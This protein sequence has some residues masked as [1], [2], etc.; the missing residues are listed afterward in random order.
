MN[1][2]LIIPILG[3][4][5]G[6]H[7]NA[8][9]ILYVPM[10]LGSGGLVQETVSGRK[11]AVNGSHSPENV[12]GASGK[13][14]RLDGYSS[15]V[16]GAIDKAE[17]LNEASFSLW[18]APE[19][20]PVI[21]HD[22][23]T[24]DRILMGG[25]LSNSN[26]NGWGFT[27]GYTG[28]YAF[29]A[30]S[31]GWKV[32][33][34]A[35][36]LLPTYEWSHLVAVCDSK[37]GTV[38]LYRNG[39]LVGEGRTMAITDPGDTL[40]IGKGEEEIKSGPFY[41]NTFNGLVDELEVF[42]TLMTEEEIRSS[43]PENIADLTIPE[44]RFE[45]EKLRPVF[46]GMPGA[47]WT[48]ESHGML[49]ADGRYHVFFQKN[50]NG[51]YMSRL[52]WGH[53]SSENLYDWREEKIAIAPGENYDIKGCWSG[54][55]FVD[56]VIG[57]GKPSIVYTAVDY[58]R[59]VI[60]QAT[61]A[62]EHL[63]EWDKKSDNPIIN[64]RPSGLSDDFRDPYFFRNGDKA[65]II[66]GSSKDGV[67]TTTLHEYN[68][69]SGS[70]SN[71]GRLFF[72]GSS[73]AVAGEFWEMPNVTKM[74]D[75]KW[76]FTCTPLNTA[77]GVKTL[78]WTGTIGSDGKFIPD[79]YSSMPRNFELISKQGYGLLSPTIYSHDGKVI[80]LGI[81]PDKL[82]GYDNYSLGWAHN[83]SF[84][85]ELSLDSKGNL[86]QKPFEGLKAL[87]AQNHHTSIENLMLDTARK[88][89]NVEG[90]RIEA[91]AA[92]KVGSVPFGWR[93]FKNATGSVE[94]S[95]NPA[96]NTLTI[97]M[98]SLNR[99]SND[100]GHY[101]GIYQTVLPEKVSTGSELILDVFA[102]GSILDIF[103]NDK[104]ATSHR[105]F[106]TDADAQ[107]IEIFS[108]GPTEVKSA[109]VWLLSSDA[110]PAGFREIMQSPDF[111]NCIYDLQ[112]RKLAEPVIGQI[113]IS[114]GHKVLHR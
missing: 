80:A 75:G 7:V 6:W 104:W 27:L 56:D 62:D 28:K 59:A 111:D 85:R 54:C 42:D 19:T 61:S 46:H 25:T 31:G 44:T 26:K 88:I 78:Y 1:K 13:A 112:G 96:N 29:E 107:G 45:N 95:F 35:S 21:K 18:V 30:Y 24:T 43:K 36:D 66:V 98:T 90:T 48:N 69:V 47:N 34:V 4:I 68:P 15:F 83:Y 40:Y 89:D 41:L 114:N 94:I 67:G 51:P 82:S 105:V 37:A 109:D 52:H 17:A 32:E 9:R 86:I 60:A 65:Y 97:D 77:S 22:T 81:V 16:K 102:D 113:S 49:Y 74:N 70:W 3:L 55:V 38:R 93:I 10:D 110:H 63:I 39:I 84:P 101:D 87:R 33:V 20:Y 57:G 14:L 73:K 8:E 50:A 100:R 103:V 5:I 72:S 12:P 106:P 71:D 58:A 11:L 108:D 92:F 23:P 99:L 2:K 79:E 53:I 91:R 76:L 64:G